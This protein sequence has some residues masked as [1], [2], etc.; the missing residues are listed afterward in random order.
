MTY[1]ER[2]AID[3]KFRKRERARHRAYY[4]RSAQRRINKVEQS[5]RW[6]KQNPL[7]YAL[8]LKASDANIASKK[9]GCL[10]KLRV[11][12][13]RSLILDPFVCYYCSIPLTKVPGDRSI[14]QI[15]HRIPLSKGGSNT[16]ANIVAS[17]AFCNISK[18]DKIVRKY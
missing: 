7:E 18:G 17:C 2:Y 15:D 6:R 14:W 8:K 16:T 3:P 5:T 13:I 11:R 1:K 10:G 9:H 12:D 4:A